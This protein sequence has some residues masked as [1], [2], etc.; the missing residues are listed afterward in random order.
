M[1]ARLCGPAL[2]RTLRCS[3]QRE[4]RPRHTPDHVHSHTCPGQTALAAY[5]AAGLASWTWDAASP[6]E[7]ARSRVKI[8]PRGSRPWNPSS[9]Q[10]GPPASCGSSLARDGGNAISPAARGRRPPGLSRFGCVPNHFL[11]DMPQLCKRESW[12]LGGCHG[13][14][15][16]GW[17]PS[18][19]RAQHD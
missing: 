12:R 18:S 17:L 9:S 7:L 5:G 1:R 6:A 10:P 8:C 19:F 15:P 2:R 13:S 4:G 14:E 11:L 16:L 3:Q